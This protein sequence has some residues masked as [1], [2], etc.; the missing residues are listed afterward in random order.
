MTGGE[1]FRARNPAE[2]ANIYL[3]LDQLE[4]I[5]Q[6]S[7]SYRPRQALGYLPLL[8]ALLISFALALHKLWI[9]GF[10][11]RAQPGVVAAREISP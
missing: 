7:A 10:G 9:S 5:E 3:L 2:L 1:Y 8:L 11:S 6:Q 4:P